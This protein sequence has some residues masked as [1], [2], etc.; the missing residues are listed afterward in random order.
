MPIEEGRELLPVSDE[1]FFHCVF[2][3]GYRIILVSYS[4]FRVAGGEF[5]IGV[6]CAL[7]GSGFSIRIARYYAMQGK[8]TLPRERDSIFCRW[9]IES[10]VRVAVF[11]TTGG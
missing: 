9:L 8:Y 4:P 5:C 6:A 2:L 3:V 11:R 1:D 10:H 7:R